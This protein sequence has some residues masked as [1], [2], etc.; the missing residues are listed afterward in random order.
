MTDL[1]YQ[2]F[3]FSV[4]KIRLCG[5]KFYKDLELIMK[6]S[7][8]VHQRLGI[9]QSEYAQELRDGC[10]TAL[11]DNTAPV[12][13]PRQLQVPPINILRLK[14]VISIVLSLLVTPHVTEF[15]RHSDL[16]KV[17][18]PRRFSSRTASAYEPAP[19]TG[20][21]RPG[22]RTAAAPREAG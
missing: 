13:P 14:P 7:E 12:Q 17:L 9:M 18:F 4:N 20:A 3:Q 15:T 8:Q 11:S 1:S 10:Q 16:P 6:S 2:Q 19:A 5:R 21:A 22:R